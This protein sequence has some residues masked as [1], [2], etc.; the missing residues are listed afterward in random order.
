MAC[1]HAT[2]IDSATTLCYK[3][4]TLFTSCGFS[5]RRGVGGF[6]NV[7]FLGA[8]AGIGG[9]LARDGQGSVAVEFALLFTLMLTMLFGVSQFGIAFYNK[10]VLS[11]ATKAS[12]RLLAVGRTNATVWAD[13]RTAF[14]EAAPSLNAA[15]VTLT[16]SINGTPC[17]SN[18]TCVAAMATA[19]GQ[20]AAVRATYP[21]N[22]KVITD[23][24]PGCRLT[25]V[26]TQK[27][28]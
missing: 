10:E 2:Q 27:V 25:S 28:E 8:R 21:C 26:S 4:H 9:R 1:Q 15:G 3:I 12:A 23:F 22:L 16:I 17:S 19:E 13:A 7:T 14:F 18:G 11:T 20:P 5:S 24:A 6:A